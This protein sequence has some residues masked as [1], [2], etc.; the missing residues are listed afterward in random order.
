M[1][2]FTHHPSLFRSTVLSTALLLVVNSAHAQKPQG[3]DVAL[4]AHVHGQA[5]LMI[6]ADGEALEIELI[7]PAMNLVGF[8]HKAKSKQEVEAVNAAQ[9][10]LEKPDQLFTFIEAR[11]VLTSSA[12]DIEGLLHTNSHAHGQHAHG[13]HAHSSHQKHHDDQSRHGK[14]GHHDEHRHHDRHNHQDDH[15]GHAH[16]EKAHVDHAH[17]KHDQHS[18]ITASYSF[19]CSNPAEL[20]SLSTHLLEKFPGIQ[21]IHAQWITESGQGAGR[22]TPKSTL[23]KIR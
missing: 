12:V 15:G 20:V 2:R 19:Q 18:E 10:I 13:Q 7:S 5:E 22:L 16:D 8:E 11:C 4:G 3:H 23:I 17:G 21:E 1:G 14:D 6:A 9:R